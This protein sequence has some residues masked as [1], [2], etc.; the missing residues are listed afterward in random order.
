LWAG[1]RGERRGEMTSGGHQKKSKRK[2]EKFENAP[3]TTH[4]P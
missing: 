2:F 1:D 4:A 3:L